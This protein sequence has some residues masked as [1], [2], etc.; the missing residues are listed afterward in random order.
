MSSIKPSSVRSGEIAVSTAPCTS[1]STCP[2]TSRS[3]ASVSGFVAGALITRMR[4]ISSGWKTSLLQTSRSASIFVMLSEEAISTAGVATIK[5]S[6]KPF[7]A[8][9]GTPREDPPKTALARRRAS[10]SSR[11]KD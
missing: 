8:L 10:D 5:R 6:E 4:V 3:I 9:F 1:V 11:R 2:R 7:F